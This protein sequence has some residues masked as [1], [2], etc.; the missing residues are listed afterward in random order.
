MCRFLNH[1]GVHISK[2]RHPVEW[3]HF[4]QVGPYLNEFICLKD[5][6]RSGKPYAWEFSRTGTI[7]ESGPTGSLSLDDHELMLEAALSGVGL[8]YVWE[9]RAC[10]HVGN[11]SLVECQAS[12]S[13]PED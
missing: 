10:P 4:N 9:E 2:L 1:A 6:V 3:R 7:I 8:A 11:G 5:P 12:W 13:A